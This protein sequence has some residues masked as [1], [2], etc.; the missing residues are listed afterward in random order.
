MAFVYSARRDILV[1]VSIGTV[2]VVRLLCCDIDLQGTKF[3]LQI[4]IFKYMN[5]SN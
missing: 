1:C 5:C 4:Y 3:L 2:K